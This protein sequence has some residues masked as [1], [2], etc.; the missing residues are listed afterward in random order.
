[1]AAISAAAGHKVTIC[2]R[3]RPWQEGACHGAGNALHE[4][5]PWPSF[6]RGRGREN[7]G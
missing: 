2:E 6:L 1:M 4:R 5:E 3:P 7:N